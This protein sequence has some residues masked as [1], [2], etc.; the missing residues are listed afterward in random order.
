MK[1]HEF[2]DGDPLDSWIQ[3]NAIELLIKH[4]SLHPEPAII[5]ERRSRAALTSG[6]LSTLH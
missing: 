5:T 2:Y 1:N 3:N 6:G 4:L